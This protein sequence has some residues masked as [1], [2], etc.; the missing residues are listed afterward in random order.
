MAE[1]PQVSEI[2]INPLIQSH[3]G[4]MTAVDS[5][6]KLNK[7]CVCCKPQRVI[8][9]H[10]R[11]DSEQTLQSLFTFLNAFTTAFTANSAKNAPTH[12]SGFF[13]TLQPLSS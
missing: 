12:T 6:F 9:S 5:V 8:R 3:D 2:D 13:I 10:P 4:S 7:W 11:S 1:C